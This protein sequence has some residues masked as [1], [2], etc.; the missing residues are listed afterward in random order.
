MVSV[1]HFEMAQ[2]LSWI[3]RIVNSDDNAWCSILAANYP[4]ILNVITLGG[5]WLDSI[6]KETN[7]FWKTVFQYWAHFCRNKKVACNRDIL[8]SC[9]WYNS[10]ISKDMFYSNW[11]QKGY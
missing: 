10:H 2:K 9:L 1:F 7:P 5:E 6:N 8:N 11:Y 4:K 3:K